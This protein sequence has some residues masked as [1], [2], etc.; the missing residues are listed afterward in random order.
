M[1]NGSARVSSIHLLRSASVSAGPP[2][3]VS[4]TSTARSWW[5]TWTGAPSAELEGG[6]QGLVAADDLVD[7]RTQ[8]AGVD[9][10][11]DTDR[12]GHDVAGIAGPELFEEP[13]A[14]LQDRQREG[15]LGGDALGEQ[16]VEAVALFGGEGC[17]LPG[18][19]V[20]GHFRP[21]RPGSCDG[22]AGEF[23]EEFGGDVGGPGHR[24]GSRRATPGPSC[25]VPGTEPSPFAASSLTMRSATLR[26]VAPPR[27]SVTCKVRPAGCSGSRCAARRP[28]GSPGRSR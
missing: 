13:G 2:R 8:Q 14:A 11:F 25:A 26:M 16:C 22:G 3:S 4:G 17:Q 15:V 20:V 1:S 12:A 23:G 9:R 7:R 5:T 6:A 28:S 24:A 10:A 18:E 27:K 19:V 21:S